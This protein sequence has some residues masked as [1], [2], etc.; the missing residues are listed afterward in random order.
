MRDMCALVRFDSWFR[1]LSLRGLRLSPKSLSTLIDCLENNT[2]VI[3][4]ALEYARLTRGNPAITQAQLA[5]VGTLLF[6]NLKLHR[7]KEKRM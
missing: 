4:V 6:K 2:S 5:A 3:Q 7:A 1:S